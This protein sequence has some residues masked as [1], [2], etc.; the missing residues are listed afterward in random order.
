MSAAYNTESLGSPA[1]TERDI[2][3]A[4]LVLDVNHICCSRTSI[5]ERKIKEATYSERIISFMIAFQQTVP[6]SDAS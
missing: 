3:S 5:G 1:K 4:Q 6:L 2:S